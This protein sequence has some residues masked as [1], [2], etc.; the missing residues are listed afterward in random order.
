MDKKKKRVVVAMSGG[1]DSSVAALLLAKKN[2]EVIGV[3]MKNWNQPI[4]VKGS[5]PWVEDQKDVRKVCN[6]I[7]IPFYTF[8]F[9]KEYEQRVVKYFFDE[10]EKG[11]TPN[12]D[13]LCNKEIK[14]DI[15]RRKSE[16]LGADF[17]ATG[18]YVRTRKDS[19]GLVHLLKGKDS[20]KDQS[21]FLWML[22]QEELK[23][24]LFPV[25]ELEKS[26]VRELAKINSLSTWHKKDSQGICFIGPVKVRQF[27]K[28]RLKPRRGN[29]ITK[30]GRVVAEHEGIWFYTIGQ[31]LGSSSVKWPTADV[32][33]LYVLEKDLKQNIL[34]VGTE[35]ELYGQELF[36]DNV[37]WVTEEPIFPLSAEVSIRYRHKPE[38]AIITRFN[39]KLHIKFDKPQRAISIGQSAVIYSGEEL[40][41]GGIISKKI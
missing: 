34:I 20:N 6:R 18:H 2:Y 26:E 28:S 40:L 22:G 15:F 33:T 17:I 25:G 27:L 5:C 32:P 37:N 21:Y 13:V 41:G 4:D 1:V 24:V 19:I 39:N 23:N 36:C 3:F 11:R 12:P 8:N 9:E 38:K 30:D 35:G 29:A 31:R 14:F 16:D 7:N 10:Y